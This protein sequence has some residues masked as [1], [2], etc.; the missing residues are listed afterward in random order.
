MKRCYWAFGTSLSLVLW[1]ALPCD[2]VLADTKENPYAAIVDRN[3]FGLKPIPPP[4]DPSTNAPPPVAAPPATVE[5]TGITSILSQEKALLEIVPGPG[6]PMIKPPP[7]S[8]GERVESVELVAIHMDKNEV[9]IKNGSL[10]TNLTFKVSK[11]TAGNPALAA[12]AG[13]PPG[14][15]P[16]PL[17]QAAPQSGFAQPNGRNSVMVAGG[18]PPPVAP[19]PTPFGA[20]SIGATA[21]DGLRTIPSR[22]I[23]TTAPQA[24]PSVEEHYIMTELNRNNHGLP[25]PGTPLNPNPQQPMHR[26]AGGNGAQQ[27]IPG[28]PGSL[29]PQ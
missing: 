12:G 2:R 17:H 10:V 9:T 19:N 22:N 6:K 14:L 11:P 16:P 26:S 23:R 24:Q 1:F 21:A 28:V 18:A 29:V 15:T 8:V 20:Q 13:L 4:P 7:M 3:P 25:V 5:L 27:Q